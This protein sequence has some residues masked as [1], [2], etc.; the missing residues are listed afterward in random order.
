MKGTN[1]Y[2]DQG[3]DTRYCSGVTLFGSDSTPLKEDEEFI[4][5][6]I[7]RTRHGNLIAIKDMSTSHIKNCIKMI[8]R[9]NDTWRYQYLK[10]FEIELHKRNSLNNKK[11]QSIQ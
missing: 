8:H 11:K 5:T 7:W 1:P 2:M 9:S 4:P 10:Y 6:S 3:V